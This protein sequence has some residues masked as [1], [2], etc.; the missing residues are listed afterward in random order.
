MTCGGKSFAILRCHYHE[1]NVK[2]R[3]CQTAEFLEDIFSY[4]SRYSRTMLSQSQIN[5][6]KYHI[7]YISINDKSVNENVTLKRLVR[8]RE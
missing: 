4:F 5:E 8:R 7:Q 6:N 1:R 2:E 3:H